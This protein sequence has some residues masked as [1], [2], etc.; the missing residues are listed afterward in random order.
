MKKLFMLVMAFVTA[1]FVT[2]C[3]GEDKV[4]QAQDTNKKT[5]VVT[6]SFLEDMVHQVAGDA[7]NIDTIIPAGEDPHLYVAKPQDLDKINGGDLI[8]YHG[9]HF[10][11]KMQDVLE[12]T[13]AAVTKNFKEQD[14]TKMEEDGETIIDPHFWFDIALYKQAVDEVTVQLGNLLPE[15]KATFEANADKYKQE[16]DALHEENKRLLG[17][18]PAESRYLIT[19]HDAFNYFARSY[20]I[21]VVAP[22][23]VSTDSEVA[24]KDIEKTAD[25]IVA[26]KVK[27]IFSESTTN[28]ERM[29][30]LQEVVK[31]KSHDVKV[32]S[33]EGQELY[34]DSLAPKGQFG[35]SFIDM[36][37]HN[38]KL[39]SDNLR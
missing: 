26:H 32:V 22:Q 24:N 17:E 29:Q 18:I 13:G 20:D 39:I 9:L 27:A 8:L 28:P 31:S 25:F 23:G 4:S 34:S 37:K 19:P 15:Q 2:A 30:K 21:Q 1:F 6:T 33:G 16:L 38:V 11:G 35:S 14:L 12:K 3:G 5:V 7:V 10:E 36:Y